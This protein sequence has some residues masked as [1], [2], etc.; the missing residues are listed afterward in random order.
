MVAAVNVEVAWPDGNEKPDARV[1]SLLSGRSRLTDSFRPTHDH[2]GH[3]LPLDFVHAEMLEA[4][5]LLHPSDH[6][7][8]R[9]Y[10]ENDAGVA[11]VLPGPEKVLGGVAD[12]VLVDVVVG[13]VDRGGQ[14]AAAGEEV[15]RVETREVLEVV[16]EVVHER[17][18]EIARR[19]GGLFTRR[20]GWLLRIL[21][22][23]LRILRGWLLRIL[24]LGGILR[25][26]GLLLRRSR[27]RC[28]ILGE[29]NRA[30]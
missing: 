18:P 13:R 3:D 30:R 16:A 14:R 24:R 11:D 28:R 20:R 4:A 26:G 15:D 22:R 8:R 9:P 10:C 12:E 17:R 27:Q 23:L 1:P 5:V 21:R 7:R 19:L 25:S 29:R 2:A 6:V